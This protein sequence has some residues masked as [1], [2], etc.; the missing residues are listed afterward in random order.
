MDGIGGGRVGK[1][2]KG[3]WRDLVGTIDLHGQRPED[4]IR[5]LRDGWADVFEAQ[6][7]DE[8]HLVSQYKSS[9]MEEQ[10]DNQKSGT[11]RITKRKLQETIEM[12][13]TAISPT[14]V[15][16]IRPYIIVHVE[17]FS[18]EGERIV[19]GGVAKCR[20]NEPWN[21]TLGTAI[22]RGRAIKA[23]ARFYLTGQS[24]YH[25]ANAQ[26]LDIK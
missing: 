1:K 22:A 11:T 9:E 13:E 21:S 19:A 20:A 8:M 25:A 10:M 2:R 26:I 5:E 3:L 12:I 23:L 16:I 17:W 15:D 6:M 14:W 4:A 7:K 24:D 18:P